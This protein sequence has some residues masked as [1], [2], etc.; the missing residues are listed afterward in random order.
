VEE[1]AVKEAG[2]G[3]GVMVNFVGADDNA[4]CDGCAEAMEGNPYLIDEAPEP[5]SHECD[6]RCRHALQIAEAGE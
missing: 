1:A 6:G 2:Q 3:T 5:G 4:T